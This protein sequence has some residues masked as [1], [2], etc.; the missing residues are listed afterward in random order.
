MIEWRSVFQL[1]TNSKVRTD[2]TEYR[3]FFPQEFR[4][5]LER[6]GFR[7]VD[8]FGDFK[9]DHK[10]LGGGRLITVSIKG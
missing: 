8:F 3:L 10:D 6:N 1:K 7:H 9:K 4:Y 5:F 2:M